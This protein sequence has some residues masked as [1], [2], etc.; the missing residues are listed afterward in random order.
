MAFLGKAILKKD[1]FTRKTLDIPEWGG[2]IIVRGLSGKEAIPISQGAIEIAGDQKAGKLN[3]ER[4]ER[5][6][7]ATV[8]AGWINEDGSNVLTPQDIDDLLG[9]ETTVISRI[10]KEIRILSGMAKDKDDDP[11]PTDV[12]KKNLTVTQNGD[13][14]SV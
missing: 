12:A 11:K 4:N 6:E 1:T 10:A 9:K 3:A 2:Q 14:G 5:W 13:S 8:V 7:A